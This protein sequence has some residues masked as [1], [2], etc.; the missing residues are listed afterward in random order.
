MCQ[1]PDKEEQQLQ[2]K[3]GRERRITVADIELCQS[4]V[5]PAR[6]RYEFGAMQLADR[7]VCGNAQI[8]CEAWTYES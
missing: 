5:F 4:A 8:E 7:M 3:V 1:S 2:S 6:H